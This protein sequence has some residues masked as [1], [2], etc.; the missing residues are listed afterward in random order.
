MPPESPGNTGS[1][2]G[3]KIVQKFMQENPTYTLKSL[4]QETDAQK[5]LTLSKYKP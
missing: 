5:I 1:W 2:L 4:M 3:W